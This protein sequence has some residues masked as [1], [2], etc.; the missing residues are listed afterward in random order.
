M[1]G[2]GELLL[3]GQGGRVAAGGGHVGDQ[4]QGQGVAVGER[5][6]GRVLGGRDAAGAEV[7]QALGRAQVAQRHHPDEVPPAGVGQPARSRPV[8]AGQHHQVP[9]GQL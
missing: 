2:P 3:G 4:R 8:A 5:Q 9:V 1:V 6:H 7:G